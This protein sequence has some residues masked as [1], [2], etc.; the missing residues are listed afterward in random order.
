MQMTYTLCLIY[1]IGINFF[2]LIEI[3]ESLKQRYE[4]DRPAGS[5]GYNPGPSPFELTAADE[6]SRVNTAENYHSR[7]SFKASNAAEPGLFARFVI[8]FA[9]RR[10]FVR[11][12][13]AAVMLVL[14]TF[15]DSIEL[16]MLI[17]SALCSSFI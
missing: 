6:Q 2:P 17:N 9:E 13:V 14:T 5:H 10:L 15:V 4:G 8:M 11:F 1:N 7:S 12:T 3:I 16:P